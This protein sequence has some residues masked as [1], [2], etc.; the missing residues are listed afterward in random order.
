MLRSATSTFSPGTASSF[1]VSSKTVTLRSLVTVTLFLL[2]AEKVTT[3]SPAG[4]SQATV[5]PYPLSRLVTGSPVPPDFKKAPL[6]SKPLTPAGL[7]GTEKFSSLLDTAVT[8]T[9]TDS[10]G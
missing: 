5:P 2:V 1:L 8:P 3:V 10:P 7:L 9:L 4:W 6:G